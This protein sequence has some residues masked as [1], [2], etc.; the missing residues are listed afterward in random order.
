MRL[1]SVVSRE[2]DPEMSSL[3][4]PSTAI[5]SLKLAILD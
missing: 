1:R 2:F 4:T 5:E 3:Q